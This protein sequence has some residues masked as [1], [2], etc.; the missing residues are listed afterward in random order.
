MRVNVGII[1]FLALCVSLL[2]APIYAQYPEPWQVPDCR[3]YRQ[4]ARE[5]TAAYQQYMRK[6][7]LGQFQQSLAQNNKISDKDKRE[8]LGLLSEYFNN[9]IYLTYVQY[10]ECLAYFR[11]T[12]NNS[13]LSQEQKVAAL[14]EYVNKN[15]KQK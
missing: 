4:R 14:Q 7:T 8:L 12:A 15:V 5:E 1:L 9:S 6:Y 2:F 11:R 13:A 3:P 10:T